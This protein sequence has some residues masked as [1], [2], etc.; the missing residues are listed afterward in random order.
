MYIFNV[1][2]YLNFSEAEYILEAT[3]LAN[4]KKE[5]CYMILEHPHHKDI[6]SLTQ[7]TYKFPKSE[8]LQV[9]NKV[10]KLVSNSTMLK[11]DSSEDNLT[12]Q[13]FSYRIH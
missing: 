3:V 8:I 11:I 7:K 1:R 5:C 4:S 2:G 6:F 13:F 9:R 10:H 12:P